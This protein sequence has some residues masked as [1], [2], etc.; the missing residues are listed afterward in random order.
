[1]RLIVC[2]GRNYRDRDAVFAALDAVH[3][4]I[5]VDFLIQGAA[6]GGDYLARR[7]AESWSIPCGSYPA[8]WD[9]H[10]RKAGIL[11]NQLMI[12][13]GKPN[14]VVAFPGGRGTADMVARAKK[15]GIKVWRPFG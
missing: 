14:G 9:V 8:Q 1:M 5:G 11:R 13:E 4:K 6:A 2:G 15:S 7:W 3:R 12:D 10:G